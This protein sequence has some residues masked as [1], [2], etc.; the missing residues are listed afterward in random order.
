[1]KKSFLSIASGVILCSALGFSGTASAAEKIVL[2]LGFES[3]IDS[4]QG[5]GAQAMAKLLAE[6][7]NGQIELQL[8]PDSKLG[9]GPEMIDMVREG[10]LDMFQGGGGYFGKFDGRLNVFDIPYL[11]T[12]V[13]D[14]YKVM[15]GPFGREML[16]TLE[17]HGMKGLSFWE[18]GIRS[19]T[20]KVRPINA[21][22]DLQGLRM[23][24]MLGNPVH[25]ELWKLFG[26]TPVPLPGGKIVEETLKDNIDG[27]EHPVSAIYAGGYH[28]VH[29]YLS[30]TR[31][32]Y[33]PLIQVMNLQKF[34]ALSPDL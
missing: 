8:F 20:N 7:S 5:V 6:K 18:N 21:P 3:G 28:K 14:A 24:I 17:P 9:T 30:M 2:G 23:R 12:S 26:T 31:H 22:V 32:M 4:A 25:V 34:N 10:K 33:G 15:D 1:M 27:Q 13:Q 11:F 19:V 16:A 29:K